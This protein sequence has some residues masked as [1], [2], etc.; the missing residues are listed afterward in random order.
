[1]GYVD[2]PSLAEAEAAGQVLWVLDLRPMFKSGPPQ[3]VRAHKVTA[4]TRDS[5]GRLIEVTTTCG[6]RRT[7]TGH[8]CT[9]E[10]KG[11][12]PLAW[13]SICCGQDEIAATVWEQ[14]E[15]AVLRFPEDSR[16][17]LHC[18]PDAW[19]A[20]DMRHVTFISEWPQG[21]RYAG[22][23]TI[24]TEIRPDSWQLKHNGEVISEGR[25]GS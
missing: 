17:V 3:P 25:M 19:L 9:V 23:C 10:P 8:T 21:L 2:T 1:M 18:G 14:L 12:L 13:N 22:A 6:T 11:R 5:A 7:E 4:A 16:F 20:F 15:Q 24:D